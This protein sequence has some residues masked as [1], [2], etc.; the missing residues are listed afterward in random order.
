MATIREAAENFK[1]FADGFGGVIE[2]CI[3]A[4]AD[5]A[6]DAV[7][8][9]M[10]SGLDGDEKEL[11]PS[12]LADPYFKSRKAAV[13]Y[14]RWKERITPP[15]ASQLGLRERPAKTP[16]LRINGYYRASIQ[17][18]PTQGGLRISS[19][20]ADFAPDVER[21][22]GDALYKLGRTARRKFYRDYLRRDLR[23]YYAKFGLR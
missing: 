9:Q 22:Y 6:V 17:A 21:K 14:M 16:N 13:G 15:R 19:H 5:F 11:T 2:Q 10:E 4:H 7:N 18:A 1:R 8:E 20:G 3:Q 23:E 12:Y